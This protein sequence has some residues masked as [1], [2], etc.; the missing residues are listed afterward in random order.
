[1]ASTSFPNRLGILRLAPRGTWMT[2]I[3]ITF[4]ISTAVKWVALP[5]PAFPIFILPGFFLAKVTNSSKD[6]QGE[7]ART[8]IGMAVNP[9]RATC[10]KASYLKGTLPI[11]VEVKIEV[12]FHPTVYPSGADPFKAV[13]MMP[14]PAPGLLIGTIGCP[15]IFSE[16]VARARPIRS[17]EPPAPNGIKNLIGLLGYSPFAHARPMPKTRVNIAMVT[18]FNFFLFIIYSLL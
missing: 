11:L 8:A 18:R 9:I 14:P 3:P 7:S 17:A 1:M 2:F 12:E 10:T 5:V 6:F 13:Y 16:P 15:R 4:S